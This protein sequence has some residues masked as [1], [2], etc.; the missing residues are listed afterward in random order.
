[1]R[2]YVLYHTRPCV[3]VQWFI[4]GPAALCIRSYPDMAN[5]GCGRQAQSTAGLA[6]FEKYLATY[7]SSF[8][9]CKI[10][11]SIGTFG[12]KYGLSY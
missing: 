10:S 6:R 12:I 1:M 2:H 7:G 3:I 4:P 9:F 11:G 8:I 5:A